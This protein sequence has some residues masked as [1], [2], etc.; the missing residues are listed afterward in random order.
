MSYTNEFIICR[1]SIYNWYRLVIGIS[2]ENGCL[3]SATSVKVKNTSK[4]SGHSSQELVVGYGVTTGGN[5]TWVI[6]LGNNKKTSGFGIVMGHPP[7]MYV[8][9]IRCIQ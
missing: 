7:F 8:N 9:I 4:I 1:F 5:S 6:Y 3:E 2:F